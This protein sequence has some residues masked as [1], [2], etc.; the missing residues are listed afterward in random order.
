[1]KS[2]PEVWLWFGSYDDK[3]KPPTKR[4]NFNSG[5]DYS[6][7]NFDVT[8]EYPKV[9]TPIFATE[10][11]LNTFMYTQVGPEARYHR[12]CVTTD[13]LPEG[14]KISVYDFDTDKVVFGTPFTFDNGKIKTT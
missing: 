5:H 10:R 7:D 11:E 8:M 12:A 9:Y 6:G 4:F 14:F 1:M 3:S 2:K 13:M